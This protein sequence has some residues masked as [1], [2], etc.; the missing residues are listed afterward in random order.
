[1]KCINN[2]IIQK[3]IDK[4]AS[5]KE[6][7]WVEQHIAICEACAGR[8]IILQKRAEKINVLLNNSVSHDISIPAFVPVEDVKTKH[9][10]SR[11]KIIVSIA[12][13]SIVLFVLIVPHSKNTDDDKQITILYSFDQEVDANQPITKQE[14]VINVI[15]EAGNVSEFEVN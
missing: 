13:A 7:A 6:I 1:M 5:L 15:D 10:I 4:E 12:A 8:L 14:M 3:Y 9:F 11:K 2:E